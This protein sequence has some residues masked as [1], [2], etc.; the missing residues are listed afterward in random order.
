M[1][2][3]FCS[4]GNPFVEKNPECDS[5]EDEHKHT[6][7]QGE[8]HL[9]NYISN[10]FQIEWDMILLTVFLSILNQMEFHLIQNQ[11][12]NSYHDHFPFNLKG[13]GN[14]VFSVCSYQIFKVILNSIQT[15][16]S[17]QFFAKLS[18]CVS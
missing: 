8:Q 7:Q 9:K 3:F 15:D 10:S 6:C 13:N 18:F 14:I 16:N 5:V 17:F 12:E 1:F 2:L 4:N 11:K